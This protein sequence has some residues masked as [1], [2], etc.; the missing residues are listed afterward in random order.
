MKICIEPEVML[1]LQTIGVLNRGA[2]FSGVGW[3]ERQTVAGQVVIRLYDFK[4]L[5]LG[6]EVFTEIPPAELVPLLDRPDRQNLRVWAHGHPIGDGIPGP[7]N[8]S[9]TDEHTI[10]TEPL[11]GVPEMVGWSVS[12]VRTPRGWVGRVDNH[13]TRQTVHCPVE[14]DLASVYQEVDTVRARIEREA[15]SQRRPYWRKHLASS[16]MLARRPAAIDGWD[17]ALSEEDGAL[18][19]P[20]FVD[21]LD[22]RPE[23]EFHPA[24]SFDEQLAG[25]QLTF[26]PGGRRKAGHPPQASSTGSAATILGSIQQKLGLKK[27]GFRTGKRPPKG[28]NCK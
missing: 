14:P 5:D 9:G 23:D 20:D 1:R 2:E 18:D 15:T 4:L 17:D 11:G 22:D 12:I 3:C 24:L 26:L 28:R 6:S 25:C 16:R 19:D 27:F 21:W 10:Q 8:W 13:L 7:D